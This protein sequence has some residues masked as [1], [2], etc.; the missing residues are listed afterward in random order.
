LSPRGGFVLAGAVAAIVAVLI[1]TNPFNGSDNN[2]ALVQ[3]FDVG[4]IS[5]QL[6]FVPGEDSA[7]MTVEGMEPAPPGQVYQVW[8]ITNGAPSSIGFL[9]VAN[10]GAG[11]AELDAELV[12]GQTVAVTI[13][14]DG[15][16]P[17][18]TS[19]PVFGVEI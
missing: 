8:A 5:G 11:S 10:D 13:E 9:P 14:P 17:L 18:P 16:S 2:E 12:D 7:S 19:E 4:G 15:G 3:T 1:V 6:S